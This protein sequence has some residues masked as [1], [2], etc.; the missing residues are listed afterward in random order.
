MKEKEKKKKKKK[1]MD[2]D[3]EGEL[4]TL[5]NRVILIILHHTGTFL[6][7]VERVLHA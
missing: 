3:L 7:Q 2:M 1:D 5:S 6:T 4:V